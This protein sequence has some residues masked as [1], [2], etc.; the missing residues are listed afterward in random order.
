MMNVF[1]VLGKLLYMIPFIGMF[2]GSYYIYSM[3]I[4]AI[5]ILAGLSLTQ[6]VICCFY[7]LMQMFIAGIDGILEL[8]VQLWDALMPVIFLMLSGTSYFLFINE[9]IKG[10]L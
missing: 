2:I 10:I 9:T 8:E 1:D 5:Y 7:L 6:G 4:A 3:D